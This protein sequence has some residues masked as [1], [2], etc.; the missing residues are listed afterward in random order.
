MQRHDEVSIV[1]DGAKIVSLLTA[2]QMRKLTHEQITE[3]ERLLVKE[4]KS[5]TKW[6]C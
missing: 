5:D 6:Y 2:L 3:L 4:R 1:V